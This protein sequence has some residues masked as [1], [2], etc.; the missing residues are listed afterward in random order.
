MDHLSERL[1]R[2]L[3]S[4]KEPD[5]IVHSVERLVSKELSLESGNARLAKNK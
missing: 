1:L 5:T 2:S 3:K 4:H